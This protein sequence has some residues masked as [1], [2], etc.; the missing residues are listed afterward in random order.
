M[1]IGSKNKRVGRLRRPQRLAVYWVSTFLVLTGLLWLYYFYFVRVVDQFGFE[2]PHPLQSYW[3][4]GHALL[5]LPAVWI[6]GSLWHIHIKLGWRAR[7]RRW[8]G[9]TFW[10]LVLWMSLSGYSLYYIGS[11]DVRRWLSL[12]H[13]IAGGPALVVFFLHIRQ[14]QKGLARDSQPDD[15]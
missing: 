10:T 9:G 7:T 15:R 6:F 13:W 2:N 11:D 1:A 3:L 4:I 14:T 8:S 12:S 5:A